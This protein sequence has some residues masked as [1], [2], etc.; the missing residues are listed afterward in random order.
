MNRAVKFIFI[1]INI[2]LLL[3]NIE[4]IFYLFLI[5]EGFV[6][7]SIFCKVLIQN[8]FYFLI[9]LILLLKKEWRKLKIVG[10]LSL[11]YTLIIFTG[12][13]IGPLLYGILPILTTIYIIR[14]WPSKH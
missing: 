3:N 1:L 5:S 8:L 4:Y 10:L 12:P 7:Y 14:K 2:I 9:G 11:L 6:S 13:K